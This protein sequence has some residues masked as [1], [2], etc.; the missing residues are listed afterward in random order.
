LPDN[1]GWATG[2][3]FCDTPHEI[4]YLDSVPEYQE[5][6]KW[7]VFRTWV[8]RPLFRDCDETDLIDKAHPLVDTHVQSI[9]IVDIHP[10]EFTFF[11]GV[12]LDVEFLTDYGPSVTGIPIVEDKVGHPDVDK[13]VD[14]RGLKLVSY[15]I[16]LEYQDQHWFPDAY[17]GVHNTC[18]DGLAVVYRTWTTVDAC[19]NDVARLQDLHVIQ[20]RRDNPERGLW[21]HVSGAQV[22]G[23]GGMRLVNSDVSE[24]LVSGVDLELVG[25]MLATQ[26]RTVSVE[27]SE[28]FVLSNPSTCKATMSEFSV[29]SEQ[30]PIQMSNT[31]VLHKSVAYGPAPGGTS[32]KHKCGEK[33]NVVRI[34]DRQED[35]VE[36][37]DVVDFASAREELS[38]FSQHLRNGVPDLLTGPQR[39]ECTID[40]QN[41]TECVTTE[42]SDSKQN[43]QAELED[44]GETLLLIGHAPLYNFFNIDVFEWFYPKPA[45]TPTPTPIPVPSVDLETL[46][47]NVTAAPTSSPTNSPTVS[48]TIGPKPIVQVNSPGF[49]FVNVKHQV[50]LDKWGWVRT[51]SSAGDLPQG[52][53]KGGAV[54]GNYAN[55]HAL[56]KVAFAPDIA[57]GAPY[58]LVNIMSPDIDNPYN[59]PNPESLAQVRFKFGGPPNA[60]E[61]VGTMLFAGEFTSF[62]LMDGVWYGG[63][64]VLNGHLTLRHSSVLCGMYAASMYCPPRP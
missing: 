26:S 53:A 62:E 46:P 39:I 15:P 52:F 30:C 1:T 29:V 12:T 31:K 57:L 6:G 2:Q 61:L 22:V 24:D 36:K 17:G 33:G 16:S 50:E 25:S 40:T 19:H 10:P 60:R 23:L 63:Q 51:K 11:P 37:G 43:G 55:S 3:A 48:P 5:C 38:G 27:S 4:V 49:V 28:R 35:L 18:Q 13:L 58:V 64:V 42:Y 20:P 41:V 21:G 59:L 34:M 44:E 32:K 47:E 7:L 56:R 54:I 8:V 45:G 9:T 14:D